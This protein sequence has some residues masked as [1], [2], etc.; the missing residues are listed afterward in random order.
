M[1]EDPKKYTEQGELERA[2]NFVHSVGWEHT[3]L[4]LK[5]IVKRAAEKYLYNLQKESTNV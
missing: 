1:S 2:L 3:P 5:N 4:R